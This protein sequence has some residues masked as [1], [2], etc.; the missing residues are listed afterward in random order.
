ML[1]VELCAVDYSDY[2]VAS[3]SELVMVDL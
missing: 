3:K 2:K 1:H